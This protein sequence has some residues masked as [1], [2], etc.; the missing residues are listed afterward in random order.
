MLLLP[1]GKILIAYNRQQ[2]L[3]E[4]KPSAQKRQVVILDTKQR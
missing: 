4:E 1:C 3:L 2:V